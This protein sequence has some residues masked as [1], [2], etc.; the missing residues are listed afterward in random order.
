MDA[1]LHECSVEVPD[2]IGVQTEEVQV[3][4]ESRLISDT[5]QLDK[6]K[7]LFREIGVSRKSVKDW[8]PFKSFAWV[9]SGDSALKSQLFIVI[10]LI[11]S[12]LWVLRQGEHCL[13]E[14]LNLNERSIN[15]KTASSYFLFLSHGFVHV[16]LLNC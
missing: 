6:R 10:D 13:H 11:I 5:I 1:E 16:C 12:E 4:G 8:A 15:R 2:L 3:H 9:E 7:K 14:L